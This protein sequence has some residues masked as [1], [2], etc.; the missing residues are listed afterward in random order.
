MM[1]GGDCSLIEPHYKRCLAAC[2][3][4]F[5]FHFNLGDR[6][7]DPAGD[8]GQGTEQGT[9]QGIPQG[10]SGRGPSRRRVQSFLKWRLAAFRGGGG[11]STRGNAGRAPGGICAQNRR[12]W[13]SVE[14][15]SINLKFVLA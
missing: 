7:G 5:S 3:H 10:T 1:A 13:P 11:M 4:P 6:A 2:K 8:L 9:E 15:F 12:S 14:L